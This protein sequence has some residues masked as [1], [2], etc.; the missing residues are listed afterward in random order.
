MTGM[1]IT[2][3]GQS[4][5]TTRV[6][7]TN[8]LSKYNFADYDCAFICLGT[9]GDLVEGD[10]NYNAYL[11]IIEKI[12]TDN[13]LCMIFILEALNTNA[14]ATLKKISA[15]KNLPFLE[16]FTNE[17][18]YLSGINGQAVSATHDMKGDPTHLSPVGYLLLA[19]NVVTEMT[20]D[21]VINPQRYN[22]RFSV[23]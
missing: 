17:F 20:K 10:D 12:Q 4:G 3:A 11:E 6:W 9:N 21:M 1:E 15:S 19:R 8:W 2:N 22:Q 13:P 23:S 16:I 7:V 14:K 5:A 18:Y